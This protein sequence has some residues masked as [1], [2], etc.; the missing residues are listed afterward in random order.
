ML[1]YLEN[2]GLEET[3]RGS[4]G[5]HLR[6]PIGSQRFFQTDP[7]H[8]THMVTPRLLLFCRDAY[9]RRN[10]RVFLQNPACTKIP[11]LNDT[12]CKAACRDGLRAGYV[13]ADE[14]TALS[15]QVLWL[16][17]VRKQLANPQVNILFGRRSRASSAHDSTCVTFEYQAGQP[18]S[19]ISAGVNIN[20]VLAKI[21]LIYW[22]M[23]VDDHL[24]KMLRGIKEL[25]ADP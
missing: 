6:R 5:D 25:L 23:S 11:S 2:L 14:K 7:L 1:T 3:V 4:P 8:E 24:A 18:P 9:W 17:G 13:P 15:G 19:R 12:L 16:L 21:R 10:R 22:G 20:A